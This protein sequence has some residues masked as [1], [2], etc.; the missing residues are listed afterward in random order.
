MANV[1]FNALQN[2]GLTQAE[3]VK[4]TNDEG[5]LGQ[6]D[7]LKLMV[8]ELNNQDPLEPMDNSDF[9]GQI[10][11]FSAVTGIDDLQTSFADFASSLSSD[12]ALQAS[13]LIGRSVYA[14]LSEGVLDEVGTI[15]GELTLPVSSGDVSVKI[16]DASGQLI[17]NISLGTQSAGPVPFSWDGKMENGQRA[18]AGGYVVAAQARIDGQNFELDTNLLAEVDSVTLAGAGNGLQLNLSGLGSVSFSDVSRIQ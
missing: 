11:Q 8:T 12:Q 17:R 7:F 6:G 9:L 5:D 15:E 3:Q 16:S 2:L 10:A 1:D 13:S 18:P 14:P 4:K